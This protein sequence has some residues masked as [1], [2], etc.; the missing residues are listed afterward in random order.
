MGGADMPRIIWMGNKDW[1]LITNGNQQWDVE[2]R[3][4]TIPDGAVALRRPANMF[5]G[6][7]PYIIVPAAL[8]FA[9]VIAKRMLSTEPFLAISWLPLSFVF[10]FITALPLHELFHALCYHKTDRVYIGVSLRQ[11]RAFVA[12]AASLSQNR[13]ILMS[14]APSS[15]GM[16]FMIIFLIGPASEKWLITLSLLPMFMGLISPAPDYRDVHLFL[17]QVPQKAMIQP[18]ED[19]YIWHCDAKHGLSK[20]F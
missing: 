1:G 14:L 7:G 10:G 8:C 15:L 17:K 18:T 12:S 19:G 2:I 4:K 16:L 20:G 3:S 11:F 9:A 13:F 6:L 5:S